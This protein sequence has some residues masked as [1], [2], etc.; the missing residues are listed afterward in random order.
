MLDTFYFPLSGLWLNR[1]RPVSLLYAM[2]TVAPTLTSTAG[3]WAAA[4]VERPMCP[5]EGWLEC[6]S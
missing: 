4:Q 5:G 6:P 2:I 3:Q 1:V